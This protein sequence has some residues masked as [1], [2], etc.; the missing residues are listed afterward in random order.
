MLVCLFA[1]DHRIVEVAAM[2]GA[3]AN[4]ENVGRVGVRTVL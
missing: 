2:H 3:M 1:D 4:I